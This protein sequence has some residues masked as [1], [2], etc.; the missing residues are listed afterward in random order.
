MNILMNYKKLSAEHVKNS[1]QI[2]G[3][4][5]SRNRPIRNRLQQPV[6]FANIEMLLRMLQVK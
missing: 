5:T 6:C 2:A 1:G 3:V 4:P